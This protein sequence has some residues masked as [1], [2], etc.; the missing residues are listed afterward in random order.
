MIVL[1]TVKGQDCCFAE[2]DHVYYNHFIRFSQED[3]DAGMKG[4]DE[5]IAKIESEG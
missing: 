3:Y 2:S 1:S 5:I 4:L